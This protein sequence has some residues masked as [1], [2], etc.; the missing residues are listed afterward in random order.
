MKYLIKLI[1]ENYLRNLIE[2]QDFGNQTI[3]SL[4]KKK[5]EDRLL[6]FKKII[7][8]LKKM[9]LIKDKK[10]INFKNQN[11]RVPK[12][13]NKILSELRIYPTERWD[14]TDISNPD[15]LKSKL[16]ENSEFFY[17]NELKKDILFPT[18]SNPF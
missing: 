18:L 16:K 14:G 7:N 13:T 12:Y 5:N 1:N 10:I 11:Y 2:I 9:Q 6:I 17:D 15:W 3:F 4:L 8:L